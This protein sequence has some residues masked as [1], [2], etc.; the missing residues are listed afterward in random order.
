MLE[1]VVGAGRDGPVVALAR[2]RLVTTQL[3]ETVVEAEI[4]ANGVLPALSVAPV[5]RKLLHY[6]VIDACKNINTINAYSRVP[7]DPVHNLDENM[8]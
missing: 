2:P 6:K 4:V 1:H 8:S 5:V 3:D 7:S